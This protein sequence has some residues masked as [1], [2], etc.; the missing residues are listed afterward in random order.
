M[1]IAV[2]GSGTITGISVG[3]LPDG[4]VDTDTLATSVTRG[5]ILQVVQATSDSQ[6]STTSTSYVDT[7]LSASITPTATSSKIL[8]RYSMTVAINNNSNIA[9]F[10]ILRGSTAVGNGNQGSSRT[11]CHTALRGQHSDTNPHG[12]TSGEFL[13]S[14]STTSATTY[15]IQYTVDGNTCFINK[16][17]GDSD[18]AAHPS[19]LSTLTLMEVSA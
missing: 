13:D 11:K 3:G 16:A 15:K 18:V 17:T 8:V 19:P 10:Q 12:V 7:P 6:V 4:C 14:P 2:N 9:F 1:P 5:K